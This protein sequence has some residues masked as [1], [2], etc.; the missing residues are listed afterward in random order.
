MFSLATS[1][2]SLDSFAIG[3]VFSLLDA[4]FTDGVGMRRCPI[5]GKKRFVVGRA[6]EKLV[7]DVFD[8]AP[9]IEVV[10]QGTADECQEPRRS[11]AAGNAS[12]E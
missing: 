7:Q 8:V 3:A 11:F 4:I 2:C 6:S 9:D 5:P 10:S 1:I 12:S